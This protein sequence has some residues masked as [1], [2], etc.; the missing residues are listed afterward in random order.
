MKGYP[1][2][3]TIKTRTKTSSYIMKTIEIVGKEFIRNNKAKTHTVKGVKQI[4][5]ITA[6]QGTWR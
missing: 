5:K 6:Y 2:E 1:P 4:I 3:I